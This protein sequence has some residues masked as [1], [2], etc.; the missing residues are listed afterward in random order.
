MAVK[1]KKNV[2]LEA[3]ED[4]GAKNK[5]LAEKSTKKTP[6]KARNEIERLKK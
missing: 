4:S 5:P 2:Q 1:D 3:Q 6:K